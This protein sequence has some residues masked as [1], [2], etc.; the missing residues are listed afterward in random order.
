MKT[1]TEY[2]FQLEDEDSRETA[3]VSHEELRAA[4]WFDP[5]RTELERYLILWDLTDKKLVETGG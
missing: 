1:S 3:Q 2:V 5:G 4:G